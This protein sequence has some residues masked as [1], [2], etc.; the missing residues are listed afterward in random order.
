MHAGDT[1]EADAG[2]G[3]FALDESFDLFAQG[4]AHPAAM[5][6]ES[7]PFHGS[8]PNKTLENTRK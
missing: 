8:T 3:E 4:F 2:I 7:A 5:I 6:F 1:D